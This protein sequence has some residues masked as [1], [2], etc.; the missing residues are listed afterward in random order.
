M[1]IRIERVVV[2]PVAGAGD[3]VQLECH[4]KE[5]GDRLYSLKVG[6]QEGIMTFK[7]LY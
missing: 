2:P 5:E 3:G 7:N 6:G 4:Y 1:C